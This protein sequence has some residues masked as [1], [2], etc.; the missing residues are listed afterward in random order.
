MARMASVMRLP[1]AFPDMHRFESL[2]SLVKTVKKRLHK[3]RRIMLLLG[4]IV[5][6]GGLCW[7][8]VQ[9]DFD[10]RRIQ[11]LPLLAVLGIAVVSMTLNGVELA[12]CGRATGHRLPLSSAIPY[13]GIATFA[14]L[15]PVPAS[16][17]VRGGALMSVG[18]K[19]RDTASV[20]LAAGLLW[21]VMAL[22]VAAL[23]LF[24][25]V[26]LWSA[27]LGALIATA[28]IWRWIAVRGTA[29][30]A[31][32]FLAV[33]AGLIGLTMVRL[34]L[35]FSAIDQAVPFVQTGIYLFAGIIANA[36]GIVPAGLGITETI[37]AAMASLVGASG[38]AAFL[39]L[40]VNRLVTL[41]VAGL[42]ALSM[43]RAKGGAPVHKRSS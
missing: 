22:F 24:T 43:F 26:L 7:A 14:N 42:M 38:A 13:A 32:G 40:S 19:G 6:V 1:P 36:A 28:L 27:G 35:C 33:R 11:P 9:L 29:A 31:W 10:P 39:A 21:L 8:V 20:I 30:V 12:L 4:V 18:A 23:Y 3:H 5:L 34:F 41:L 37:G 2:L 16:M 17:I 25:G 15:A